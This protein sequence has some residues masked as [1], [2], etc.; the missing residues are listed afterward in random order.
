[1]ALNDPN[2]LLL[3]SPVHRIAFPP[4]SRTIEAEFINYQPITL[5]EADPDAPWD[6]YG[7]GSAMIVGT[8]LV[9]VDT[10]TGP[11]P[12]GEPIYWAR[13]I[14]LTYP[15]VFAIAWRMIIDAVPTP[16]GVFTGI[17]AGYSDDDKATVVG[18]LDDGGVKKI[19]ILKAGSGNDPSNISAW[20]GGL[21][22]TGS[23]TGDPAD[24]D[25]SVLRSYRIFRERTGIIT[26]YIDGSIAPTLLVMPDELPYLEELN[27]PFNELQGTFFGSLS[28]EAENTSTWN[29]V[30]YTSV[31]INPLQSSPSIFI[32]YEGTT[33]PEEASQP[34][35]P[36]GFHGTEIITS[37][38]FLL[39]DSTSATDLPSSSAAGLISGDFRGYF[40]IEPLL[41]E[42]FS[43]IL[44]VN[45]A[46]ITHTHG[47]TPNAVLAAIDDGSRLIQ[48]CFFPEQEAPKFSY[49]GRALP[50]DFAPYLWNQSGGATGS[51]VGQYLRIN[52]ATTV[53]GLVYYLDDLD[54]IGTPNRVVGHDTDYIL[55]F[56]TH[57][58]SYVPDLAGYSGVMSSV[59]DSLRSVGILLEEIAGQRYV[60]FHSDG[61]PILGG[62]FAFDWFDNQFHTYRAV[63]STAGNLVSLFVDG[64]FTGSIPYSDFA[65]PAPSLTGL[66]S[67]G[68]AT[69]LSV[70]AT[71]T[72]LWAY[73]NYWRV[74][75]GV[76]KF[77]GIWKGHD[78]DSL[79][80]Y[81]LPERIAGRD[82]AVNGN[83]LTDSLADF[84]A[85][86]VL[87]DDQIVIDTGS[88]KGVYT[89]DAVAP[90]GDVTK[91]TIDD[92]PGF[93]VKP[94]TVDYRIVLETDWSTYHKYRIVKESSGGVSVFLDALTDPWIH[95]DYS[96]LDLPPSAS[97]IAWTI[98]NAL[99]SVLW[100]AFDPQNISQTSWDYVRLGAVR[101]QSELGIVPH[102]Q[103][104]N[105]RNIMASYEHHQTNIV[106][107]H[108]NFWSESEGIP[109]RTEPDLL[110][111][112]NLVAFTLLNDA[113]PLVPSTQTYEVRDPQPVLVSTVGLNRPEDVLNSQAFLLNESSQRIEIV[114][115]DDVLYNCL[116]VIETTTG[117]SGLVAPAG[118][119]C[120]PD[121]GTF[122]FQNRVCLN[123]DGSVLPEDDPTAIT[124]W[125]RASDDPSHQFASAFAGILTYGT[126]STGTRTTY[127]NN[128]PLPDS[129]SLQTEV[130]FRLKV[131]LDSTG[132]LGDSQI[133]AGFSSPGVTVGLAFVTTLLGERYVL[134][135]DL[136]NGETV[137]GIPFDFYDGLYHDYRL[138]RDPGSASIQIFVDS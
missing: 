56:R 66:V 60:T 8:E 47:I 131:L 72:V 76:R 99:P 91:L 64:V 104:L 125:T 86:G 21:D 82:A 90:G 27:A 80:G 106:H 46:L 14:D 29:F 5:P 71:S 96:S 28:R 59:Y 75:Q 70:Q 74:N 79:T 20:T 122:Y 98:A 50:P 26:V 35:T 81:H 101:S 23:A 58:L 44:D 110:R 49:G 135:V 127:R 113:T 69:A 22:A 108:T 77:A 112:P 102:H 1:V 17:S 57:V 105:Q 65:T 39:L 51:M 37:S 34:W 43:T 30:R 123:Y 6:R 126:D 52:D 114:V 115:P 128:T 87:T 11:F 2:L 62:R 116:E 45:F 68:S 94:T 67:F 40:R 130:L 137:G 54:A 16:D 33:P 73:S 132:G 78:E 9:V 85:A 24:L 3:N 133:R 124:P 129:I 42:S 7:V 136:N 55:E 32:S 10:T 18:F 103:V 92:P 61:N 88:N 107:P 84:V 138:V 12:S 63:K 120:Q 119:E 134:A 48:L 97:G 19:G 31:P 36:V 25:W 93:P 38:D 53:D 109:P 89:V 100:G 118:D 95:A 13:S 15:H 83:T 121:W 117:E 111:D 41:Q 4:L